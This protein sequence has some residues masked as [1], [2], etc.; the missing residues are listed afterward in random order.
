MLE[1]CHHLL[2]YYLLV[3]L[4]DL[5]WGQFFFTLYTCPLGSICTKHDINYHMY[6]DNQQIYLSFK[7][8]Q[9]GDKENCIKRLEMCISE[10]KEWMIVNKLKLN[11]DKMEF[12]VFGTKQQL[13]KIGEVSNNIGS[14]QI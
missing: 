8:T 14:V 1:R 7:P 5:F 10:I 13:S 12:I 3:Y 9:V 4:R 6:A 2:W 11:D